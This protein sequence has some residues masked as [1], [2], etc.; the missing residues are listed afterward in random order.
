[1]A[2]C[3]CSLDGHVVHEASNA[4]ISL[5]DIKKHQHV[6]AVAGGTSKAEAILAVMRACRTGIL[7]TDEG[8]A[9]QILKMI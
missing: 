8:A 2:G 1:M 6:I 9:E 3:Y 4:G 5:K 7:V